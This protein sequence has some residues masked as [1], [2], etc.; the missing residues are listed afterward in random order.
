MPGERDSGV[1]LVTHAVAAAFDDH[2]DRAGEEQ[3]SGTWRNRCGFKTRLMMVM[4]ASF[5]DIMAQLYQP[6]QRGGDVLLQGSDR[7]R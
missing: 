7:I 2:I 5:A 1:G 4:L 6:G 3:C